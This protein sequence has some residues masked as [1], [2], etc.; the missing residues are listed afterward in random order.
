MEALYLIAKSDLPKAVA[1][2]ES[3]LTSKL[4]AAECRQAEIAN[5][6]WASLDDNPECCQVSGEVEAY[7]KM[8]DIGY[9]LGLFSRNEYGK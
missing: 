3:E 9:F 5:T 2:F 7:L 4:L 6:W 8:L 1:Q